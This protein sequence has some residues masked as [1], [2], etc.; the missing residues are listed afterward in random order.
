MLYLS[1]FTFPDADAEFDF[2]L[3]EK[4][5]C[6][7]SV[8]PFHVLSGRGLEALEFEPI[9]VLCGGNGSGKTTALNVIAEKL[10]LA[11][12]ALYNRSNFFEDYL[13]R[14]RYELRAPV[15]AGSRI[16]TSDDVFDFMLD[17]RALNAGIDRAREALFEDYQDRKR[18]DFRLR[19]LDDYEELKRVNQA[20]RLT[21]SR[22]VRANLQDNVRERSNGESAFAYFTDRIEENGL[23]LLDE[24]ENSLSP[25]HQRELAQFLEDSVR[26]F[27][28]QFVIATHSPMLLALREA[29]VY[30]LDADPVRVRR[31]TELPAVRAWYEFFA[32]RRGEFG[33]A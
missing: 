32:E 29:R 25:A 31:W 26:F 21:Q 17:V 28:C 8:Y 1:R 27:G 10:G 24:P 14:C 22:Y 3:A 30:D 20:R 33:D 6:F 12:D 13:R 15:P 16:L 19:S 7:D 23:Y 5:T 18:A 9:T 4:R 11:R 2:R